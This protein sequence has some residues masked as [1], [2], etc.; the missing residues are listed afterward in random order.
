MLK[1]IL[2]RVFYFI[3]TFFIISLVIFFLS[4]A[5]GEYLNCENA[6]VFSI[7]LCKDEA[8]LKGYDKPIFYFTF[9]TAAH[10]DTLYKVFRPERRKVLSKLIGQYG[11]WPQINNYYQQL[12]QLGKEIEIVG[13]KQSSKGITQIQKAIE[14]LFLKYKDPV[15]SSQL[16]KIENAV[17]TDSIVQFLSPQIHQLLATYTTIKTEATPN[18]LLI[19]DFKWYGLNNQ[20]HFWITNFLRGN[21]GISDRDQ[22]PVADKIRDY[23]PWTLIINLVA[24]FLAYLLSIPLGVYSAVYRGSSF[25]KITSFVLLLFFSLPVFWVG[26]LFVNFLTTPEFGLKIFPSI[27][28]SSL[29]KGSWG[30]FWDNFARLILPIFCVTYGSLAFMTRQMRRSMLDTMQQDFIRTARAKGLSEKAIIWKHGFRNSLF[31]LITI[32]GAVI[33]A[34]FAGSIIIEFI[35]NITGM[36]WLMLKSIEAKD[37]P[38]VYAVL[39]ITAVLTMIGILISDILYVLVDPRVKLDKK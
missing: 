38:V 29:P 7:Q 3:P 18:Q 17:K 32:F 35:F 12:N 19:P 31:P 22:L 21:F 14:Q 30:A 2:K 16:T 26:T 33:P 24:I 34:A 1:Y 15:I 11:N 25:D 37:W 39:M 13:N 23:L 6:Q 36:G 8:H 9:S 10:P 4:K 20:Y 28:L 27:G 5:A